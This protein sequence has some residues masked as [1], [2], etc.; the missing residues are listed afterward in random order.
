MP[1]IS[2]FVTAFIACLWSYIAYRIAEQKNRNPKFWAVCGFLFGL[3]SIVILSLMKK[4]E[5]KRPILKTEPIKI[6]QIALPNDWYFLTKTQE[7]KGPYS[8]EEFKTAFESGAFNRQ[9][10]VWNETY[11][12]WKKLEEDGNLMT[13]LEKRS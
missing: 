11:S 13:E 3:V 8:F 4:A 10:F 9:S 5:H 7:S 6:K 1:L 12:D 2:L